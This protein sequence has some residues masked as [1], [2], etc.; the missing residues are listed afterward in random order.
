M[1]LQQVVSRD[2]WLVARSDGPLRVGV[3]RDLASGTWRPLA[4]L[5]GCEQL[6]QGQV[7]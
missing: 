5:T 2:E 7:E 6:V 1:S 3:V 4:A